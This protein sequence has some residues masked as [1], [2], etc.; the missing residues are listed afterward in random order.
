MIVEAEK[1]HLLAL[2][3]ASSERKT[4]A[5]FLHVR[6]LGSKKLITAIFMPLMAAEKHQAP[7][8]FVTSSQK[9]QRTE[10]GEIRRSKRMGNKSSKEPLES[11]AHENLPLEGDTKVVGMEMLWFF[12]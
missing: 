3:R 1:K 4:S 11:G 9:R 10:H 5:Y 2:L 8:L 12:P 7:L 6:A